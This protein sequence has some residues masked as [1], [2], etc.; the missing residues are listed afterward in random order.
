MRQVEDFQRE[1]IDALEAETPKSVRLQEL[2]ETA[3]TLDV[4]LPE[5]PKLKQV[6]TTQATWITLADSVSIIC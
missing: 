2:V 3:V 6:G 1:A 5:I 4:D